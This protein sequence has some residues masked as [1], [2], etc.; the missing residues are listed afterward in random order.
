MS[1]DPASLLRQQGLQVTP[2]RLAVLRVVSSHPHIT[3]DRVA[4][5]ART[6]IGS[7]S[8][9][10]V[11]NA[12][13]IL[14]DKGLLRRIQPIGSPSD[15]F[16]Q[17]GGLEIQTSSTALQALTDA[18]IYLTSYPFECT[19]QISSRVLGVAALRDV[20]TA[21]DAEGLPSAEAM[22]AAVQRDITRLEG[23]QNYNGG[24]PSWR[25]GQDSIPFNTIHVA[26][27]LQRA[28]LKGFEV[29]EDVQERAL[30]D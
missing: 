2:Q 19:E 15:V 9:Q 10:S 11:Y 21:F 17:F 16:P 14:A 25:R 24:W 6:E 1:N 18:V 27:A 12:L 26:H 29:P 3:A 23:M 20:L 22:E 7:I 5:I 30:C 4:E 28:E 8:R 13:G